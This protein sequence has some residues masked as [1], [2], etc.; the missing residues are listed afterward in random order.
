MSVILHAIDTIKIFRAF[1]S[2]SHLPKSRLFACKIDAEVSL[3]FSDRSIR[4]DYN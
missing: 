3:S 1:A 4:L 2:E